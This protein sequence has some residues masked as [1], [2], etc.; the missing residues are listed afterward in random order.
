MYES[1]RPHPLLAQVPLTVSPFINLPTTVTLPYTYKSVP[2][3]I[4]PSVT[5]DPSNPDIKTRY[6]VS[7]SGE[8]AASPEEILASCNALEQHLNKARSDAEKAIRDWEESIAQRD[9]AEK[10][11]VAPGWL[12]RDEKLL[13]P[14][15]AAGSGT[16]EENQ[17]SLLDSSSAA[18]PSAAA[19]PSMVPHDEGEE[20]DR[21]FGGLNVK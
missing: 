16:R 12:D 11:R 17:S 5:V 15:N 3:T 9:L 20:L 19:L 21:A 2:S 1:Y 13:Q 14:L 4:P 18:D 6:V 8:H 7:S 10:R